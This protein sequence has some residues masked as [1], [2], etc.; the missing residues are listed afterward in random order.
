M[1]IFLC[2]LDTQKFPSNWKKSNVVPVYKKGDKTFAKN[3]RPVSLLPIFGKIFEK[4]LYDTIYSYFEN[5]NLF[6]TCQSGFRKGDPCISQLLSITHEIFMGFDANPPLD[7]RG[8]FLD[9]SKAF[10]RVWHDGLIHKLKN[11]G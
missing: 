9:I 2:S 11:H 8:V 5:N 1:K 6:S 4:C 3:Y 10:D 7:T